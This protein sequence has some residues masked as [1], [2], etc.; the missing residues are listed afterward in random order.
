VTARS[1]TYLVNEIN[2]IFLEAIT[3]FGLDP[4]NFVQ[5]QHIIENGLRTWVTLRQIETAYLEVYDGASGEVRTRIDL[6]IEFRDTGGDEQYKTAIDKVRT[7][8]AQTGQYPG[9]QYRVVVST[10]PGAAKVAD[11]YDTTLGSVDHL[12]RYDVGEVI[13]TSAA[14][15]SMTI[16]R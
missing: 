9:C 14:G 16:L 1:Y 12:T 7:Q 5:Q 2:R 11:W 6:N 4:S 10:V 15:A 13:G 8:I 3:G